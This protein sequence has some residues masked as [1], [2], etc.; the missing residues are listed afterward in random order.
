MLDKVTKYFYQAI[1]LFRSST[2]STAIDSVSEGRHRRSNSSV[3]KTTNQLRESTESLNQFSSEPSTELLIELTREQSKLQLN[4][5]FSSIGPSSKPTKTKQKTMTRSKTKFDQLCQEFE[6]QVENSVKVI[7][8]RVQIKSKEIKEVI[9]IDDDIQEEFTNLI[10]KKKTTN[11]TKK[12]A[13][14]FTDVTNRVQNAQ[15]IPKKQEPVKLKENKSVTNEINL[16]KKTTTTLTTL[17]TKLSLEDANQDELKTLFKSLKPDNYR[18]Q[19]VIKEEDLIF[20]DL[21]TGGMGSKSDILQVGAINHLG[22]QFNMYATPTQ[23]INGMASRVHHITYKDNQMFYRKNPVKHR[24][25]LEVLLQFIDY[26]NQTKSNNI[27]FVAHNANFDRRFLIE[28]FI[29][30]NLQGRVNAKVIGFLD[31]LPL[32]KQLIP[33]MPTYKQDALILYHFPH[34][35]TDFHNAITDVIY[36]KKLFNTVALNQMKNEFKYINAFTQ[37]FEYGLMKKEQQLFEE[38]C[39]KKPVAKKS[40]DNKAKKT[41]SKKRKA[42]SGIYINGEPLPRQRK[43][44]SSTAAS[45]QTATDQPVE[46][47]R[48]KRLRSK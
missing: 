41:N 23:P 10:K 39:K 1:R 28:K 7:E 12:V 43:T 34:T 26:L 4:N 27:V 25:I 48:S 32:F 5:L 35:K 40:T 21:E 17:S 19:Q 45:K 11:E 9:L 36:L 31:T 13:K 22:K 18:I 30:F 15:N 38:L 24:P 47:R 37:T 29:E 33:C 44:R 14:L 2:S 42:S 16:T 20:F 3:N 8:N 6:I 46:N